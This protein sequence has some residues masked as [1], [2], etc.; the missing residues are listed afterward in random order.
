MNTMVFMKFVLQ[1][2]FLGL[3]VMTPPLTPASTINFVNLTT[4]VLQP[5]QGATFATLGF[6]IFSCVWVSFLQSLE[7]ISE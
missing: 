3:L 7:C 6:L 5:R 1:C 2:W 4:P